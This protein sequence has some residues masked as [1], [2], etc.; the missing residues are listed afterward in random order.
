MRKRVLEADELEE[1]RLLYTGKELTLEE[2]AE[3]FGTTTGSLRQIAY[4]RGWRRPK[5]FYRKGVDA[6]SI[7]DERRETARLLWQSGENNKRIGRWIGCSE[8][9]AQKICEAEFG[10]RNLRVAKQTY[11]VRRNY[12]IYQLRKM[13]VSVEEIADQFWLSPRSVQAILTRMIK[14]FGYLYRG[15]KRKQMSIEEGMARLIDKDFER[16][17]ETH[18]RYLHDAVC[19][20]SKMTGVGAQYILFEKRGPAAWAH[21]RRVAMY[22]VHTVTGLSM[23]RVA[24]LFGRH[25]STVSHNIGKT[26]DLRDD[27]EFDR[28]CERT[29]QELVA[30]L[31]QERGFVSPWELYSR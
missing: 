14:K 22:L 11:M 16:D 9:T 29:A 25:R 26:E 8:N 30:Q 2:I 24:E 12:Q 4:R 15:R 31:R 7:P 13:N 28:Q 10:P 21:A 19:L 17:I 3:R 23:V 18:E 6:K 27:D 1:L 5:E 20:V